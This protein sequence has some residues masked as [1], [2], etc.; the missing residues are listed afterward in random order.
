[1][2]RRLNRII[3]T[4]VLMGLLSPFSGCV[5]ELEEQP[6]KIVYSSVEK[7]DLVGDTS[8][9]FD[10]GNKNEDTKPGSTASSGGFSQSATDEKEDNKDDNDAIKED[11]GSKYWSTDQVNQILETLD[12]ESEYL[13]NYDPLGK[14]HVTRLAHKDGEPLKV[15]LNSTLSDEVKEIVYEVLDEI[16]YILNTLNDNYR[17]EIIEYDANNNIADITFHNTQLSANGVA[18][19]IRKDISK[20]TDMFIINANIHIDE[21]GFESVKNTDKQEYQNRVKHTLSHEFLHILGLSDVYLVGLDTNSSKTDKYN[22]LTLLK[23]GTFGNNEFV[24]THITPN[25]YKNIVA[26]YS[27]PSENLEKD[28]IKYKQMV[29]D[30]TEYYYLNWAE[31]AFEKE[32][33][34]A[35]NVENGI[36]TFSRKVWDENKTQVKMTFNLTVDGDEYKYSVSDENG[37]ILETTSGQIRYLKLLEDGGK[38]LNK[39]VAIF[40]GLESKRIFEDINRSGVDVKD[41]KSGFLNLV[42]YNDG[43]KIVIKDVLDTINRAKSVTFMSNEITQEK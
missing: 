34:P 32:K 19:F 18:S 35:Q 17:Y 25:D 3:A 28:M 37:K 31:S 13:F 15:A 1:M 23:N 22:S 8:S 10:K 40:E 38:T 11:L 41:I 16:F 12:A 43:E 14:D 36:Y 7:G 24:L 27:K 2:G 29:E 6:N 39:A 5:L 30:Y 20:D 42:L 33:S 9:S 26:L 4:L 21:R